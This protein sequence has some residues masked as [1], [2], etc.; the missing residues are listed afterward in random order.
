VTPDAIRSLCRDRIESLEH[1][2]RRLI[3]D[4]L[5]ETY[6][7]YFSY[8]DSSGNRLLKKSLV[9]SVASRRATEPGRY[10]RPVDAVLLEDAIYIVC[11]PSLYHAHF[12][13]PLQLAFPDGV[14]EARTFLGRLLASR[15]HLAHANPISARQAEQVLCY[16]GDVIDSLK[17]YYTTLGM[18]R[19][20]NVP[21][22]LKVT[23]SFG[24][25]FTRSQMSPVHDGG[26]SMNFSDR[27]DMALRPGDTLVLEID[28]DPAFDPETYTIRWASTKE[29]DGGDRA[30]PVV[31]I[32]VRSRQVGQLWDVQCR[33]TSKKDWH[34]MHM[35]C[36]DFLMF[37]Y[38][39]LPPI[40]AA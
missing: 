15:N 26:I 22:I 16:T 30:S 13:L 10:P 21:T 40:N 25:E 28:V 9:E 37:H 29:W 5:S 4:A 1:W 12:R 6:G 32:P 11:H 39:V 24:N 27:P 33:I 19:A 14:E 17:E 3:D 20:F 34:R 35:G 18:N 23:D 2:L 7:D 36:D 38:V 31:T 8:T